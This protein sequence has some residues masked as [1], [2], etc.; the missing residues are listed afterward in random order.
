VRTPTI[1]HATPLPIAAELWYTHLRHA[2]WMMDSDIV[3]RMR[4][5]EADLV[6][7]LSAVR[8]F[9]A[10]YGEGPVDGPVAVQEQSSPNPQKPTAKREPGARP[11]VEI[12]S[13]TE[14]SRISVLLSMMAMTTTKHLMKTKQLVEFVEA[15]GH[16]VSGD[17]KVNALGAL[18]SRSVDI[19]SHG[20]SG[21]ELVDREKALQL[22]EQHRS[23]IGGS[24]DNDPPVDFNVI[25][26]G[27]EAGEEGA[28]PPTNPWVNPS[29]S[30]GSTS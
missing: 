27:P 7:K 10:A 14:Q 25:L 12:D 29:H 21:W 26:G 23:L 9:L 13:F 24:E 16:T 4:A 18:L 20:K 17:N 6:R 19:I 1:S 30:P 8:G 11:K 28:P 2:R 5:E 22:L 15:M 3:Q